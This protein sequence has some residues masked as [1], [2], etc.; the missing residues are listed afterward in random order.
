M[1]VSLRTD[2]F[3]DFL[4]KYVCARQFVIVFGD[5]IDQ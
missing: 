5:V 3:G 2:F 4:V 1:E